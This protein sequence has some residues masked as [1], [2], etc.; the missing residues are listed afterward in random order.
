MN[1]Q[2]NKKDINFFSIHI[3][4][5]S[6]N[7][8]INLKKFALI[9]MIKILVQSSPCR[10]FQIVSLHNKIHDISFDFLKKRKTPANRTHLGLYEIKKN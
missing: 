3:K 9:F 6:G 8:I 10:K 4:L 1:L 2:K 7:K 5:G